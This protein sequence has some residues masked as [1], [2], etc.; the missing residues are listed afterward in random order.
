MFSS[1]S[2]LP[3]KILHSS[4]QSGAASVKAVVLI[5]AEEMD[6]ASKKSVLAG[7]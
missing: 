2:A 1:F 5:S 7:R 3:E 6:N 4:E